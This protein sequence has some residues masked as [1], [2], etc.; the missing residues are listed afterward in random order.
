MS[1]NLWQ[2]TVYNCYSLQTKQQKSKIYKNKNVFNINI[3]EKKIY[4]WTNGQH[5]NK[6]E[7]TIGTTIENSGSNLKIIFYNEIMFNEKY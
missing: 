1:N 5:K 6:I 3:T 2:I 4:F 7:N